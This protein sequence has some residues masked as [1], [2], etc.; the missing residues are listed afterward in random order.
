MTVYVN[1]TGTLAVADNTAE[2]GQALECVG[3]DD[4][5]TLHEGAYVFIDAKVADALERDGAERVTAE[6]MNRRIEAV[7]EPPGRLVHG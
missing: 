6:Q 1:T 7:R 4:E 3:I 2:L 5:M